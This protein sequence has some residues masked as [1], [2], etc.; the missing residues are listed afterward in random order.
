MEI[1]NLH[2]TTTIGTFIKVE[3]HDYFAPLP[4]PTKGEGLALSDK[5]VD[6]GGDGF[7][8]PGF[9]DVQVCFKV[10]ELPALPSA[11]FIY[12]SIIIHQTV[13]CYSI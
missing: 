8:W 7:G 12:P 1:T 3:Q 4:P 10:P 11:S 13:T 9:G 6:G 2:T 5:G